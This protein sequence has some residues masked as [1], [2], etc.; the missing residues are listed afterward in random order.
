MPAPCTT[1][2]CDVKIENT[3]IK[4]GKSERNLKTSQCY[5]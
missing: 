4:I 5:V 3:R 2:K 1:K